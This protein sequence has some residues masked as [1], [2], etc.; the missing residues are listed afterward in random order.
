MS[1]TCDLI[2]NWDAKPE[3]LAA[4]GIALWRW[5]TCRPGDS[6]LYQYLDN[7][8]LADLIAGKLPISSQPLLDGG[9]GAHVRVQAEPS[10]D[11]QATLASLRQDLPGEGIEDVVV[12][13]TSWDP[14]DS[15][16]HTGPTLESTRNRAQ[17]G[18]VLDLIERRAGHRGGASPHVA[19]RGD[20][21]GCWQSF[22]RGG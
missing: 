8:A 17:G 18:P 3:Q 14:V 20:G 13:G 15:D 19:A 16:G 11:R 21:E 7:Q 6:G 9:R 4:L 12:D 22:G 1:V 10:Q 2:V 5:C